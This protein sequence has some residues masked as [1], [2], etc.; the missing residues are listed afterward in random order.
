M[1]WFA[2]ES[3]FVV[4]IY[5]WDFFS[6]SRHF[7]EIKVDSE[8]LQFIPSTSTLISFLSGE[9][10]VPLISSYWPAIEP[11]EVV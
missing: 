8:T 7:T 2:G 4:R 11:D 9:N 6:S 10:P 3:T 5:V 1:Y